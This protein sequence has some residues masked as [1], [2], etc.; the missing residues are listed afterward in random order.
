MAKVQSLEE[1]RLTKCHNVTDLTP[2]G[3]LANLRHVNFYMCDGVADV[4]PLRHCPRLMHVGLSTC[5]NVKDI[6]PL[7]PAAKRGARITVRGELRDQIW[8]LKR[9]SDF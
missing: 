4:A 3:R 2:V 9:G 7:R 5:P 6:T 8:E 1:L